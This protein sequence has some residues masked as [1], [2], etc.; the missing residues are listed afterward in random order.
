MAAN[1]K[2]IPA[3]CFIIAFSTLFISEC[4]YPVDF[5]ESL[6]ATAKDSLQECDTADELAGRKSL[7]LIINNL[8]SNS[9]VNIVF[10]QARHKFLS[11][12]DRLK[13]YQFTPDGNMLTAQIK[14]MNYGE[15]AIAFYQ[16]VNNDGKC[17][18]NF[19]GIPV[20]PYGF[21]NNFKPALKPPRFD[22]CK[23]TFTSKA[24]TLTLSMLR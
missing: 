8:A 3:I 15:F 16:D 1:Q 6:D 14:D 20:E 4:S 22:D 12:T 24:D 7:T 5:S 18:K 9:P 11:K 23:F 21:S 19:I 10:Y 2:I 13:G 17:N